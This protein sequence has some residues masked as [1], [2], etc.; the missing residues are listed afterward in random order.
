MSITVIRNADYVVAW[1][2]ASKNHT[3]VTGGDVA[4]EDGVL[5]FAGRNYQGEAGETIDGRGFMVMPGLVDI[6]SH[7]SSEPLNK[8]FL[9]EIG[10]PGLY[11]SSLYEYMPIL[12]PDPEGVPDCV[13]VAY[14]ELLLSGVTTVAD[15]SIAHP[16]WIDLAA[17]SGLRVCLAP[18]FRSARWFTP[19]G[20]L[21]DYEWN[22]KAGEDAMLHAFGIIDAAESHPSGRLSGMMCPAQIDTCT[23]ALMRDSYAEAKRRG[24]PWQTHAA[25]SVPEFL[26]MI[27]RH[28]MTPIQWLGELG[29]LGPTSLV[30]HAIFVDEHPL[31]H[32]HTRRDLALLAETG[33]TVA[34]CPTV[35]MRRGVALRDVGCYRE[36]GI[37]VAIGT[38]TYPHNM[39]EEMRNV[40]MTSRLMAGHPRGLNS[41]GLFEAATTVGA[42]ALGRDDIGRLEAGCK[43]DLVMVDVTHPMMQPHRDPIRSMIYA[44]AE[45]AVRHVYVD[46]RQVVKDGVVQTFDYPAAALRVHEAQI[47]AEERSPGLDWAGRKLT[48]ISPL[49]FP[50]AWPS[51]E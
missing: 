21:V 28:G 42:Q 37:R 29:V 49:S 45:R 17:E 51:N 48:E 43:A 23:P 9:D 27:R 18:M 39:I 20:T 35:F 10:S 11:N 19:N 40:T 8:G 12:R 36:A 24:I 4:F 33:T 2:A 38:D 34:H 15:L 41:T 25:Q 46:G 3:Y 16:Q 26:E 50:M 32:W 30:G 13:R 31:A 47:R 6:H 5:T 7:P 1:D 44:A 22:E 14:S